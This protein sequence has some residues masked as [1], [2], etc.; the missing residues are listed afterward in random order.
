MKCLFSGFRLRFGFILKP[1]N[2]SSETPCMSLDATGGGGS[3]LKGNDAPDRIVSCRHGMDHTA[4]EGGTA[5]CLDRV[6][7]TCL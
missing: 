1:H 3:T 7:G 2:G 5:E 6:C 4:L